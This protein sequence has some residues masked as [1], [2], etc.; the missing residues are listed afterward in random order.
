M[1]KSDDNKSNRTRI[2]DVDAES[3]T[4]INIWYFG[5]KTSLRAYYLYYELSLL[6]L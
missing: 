4:K 3:K 5:V 1:T 6:F 2:P